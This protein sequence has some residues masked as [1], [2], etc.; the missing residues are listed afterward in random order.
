MNTEPR[1]RKHAIA[2]G[3]ALAL[4]SSLIS[5]GAFAQAETDAEAQADEEEI[6]Y[7]VARPAMPSQEPTTRR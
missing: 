7:G 1:F 3:T 4:A 5:A 6:V 2:A